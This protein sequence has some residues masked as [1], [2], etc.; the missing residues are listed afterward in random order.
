[1]ANIR[2]HAKIFPCGG[3]KAPWRK[4]HDCLGGSLGPY[5]K[6]LSSSLA[7]GFACQAVYHL[8]PQFRHDKRCQ[9]LVRELMPENDLIVLKKYSWRNLMPGLATEF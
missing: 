3:R 5:S 8:I 2:S 1:M 4:G 6:I 7:L 9:A